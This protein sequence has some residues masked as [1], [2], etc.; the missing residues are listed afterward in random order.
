MWYKWRISIAAHVGCSLLEWLVD[1]LQV[2]YAAPFL[3]AYHYFLMQLAF[4]YADLMSSLAH[5][6][7]ALSSSAFG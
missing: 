2:L 5:F 7:A 6:L 4:F 3:Q 1:S